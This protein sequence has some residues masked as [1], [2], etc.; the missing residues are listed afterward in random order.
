MLRTALRSRELIILAAVALVLALLTLSTTTVAAG[1]LPGETV[2][3]EL[4][5][6]PVLLSLPGEG[7]EPKGLVLFFHGQGGDVN[8]RVGDP[9]L[10]TLRRDGWAVASSNYHEE[11]WGNAAST[12]DVRRLTR[13]AKEQTGLAP[14][15]Y[16]AGSMGAAVSLNAMLHGVN[17]P[18]CWYGVRPA[19]DLT[20]MDRVPGARRFIREAFDGPVPTDRDP[21]DNV[22][23]L[24]AQTR[25][26]VIASRDDPEVT[27]EQNAEV[28]V[29]SLLERGV[30]VTEQQVYGGHDDPSH[31]NAH[32][33]LAF[34]NTCLDS[35]RA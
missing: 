21:I 1:E 15:V 27:Y 34:A 7:I 35:G 17:A 26:R 23:S 4:A 29:D 12:E 28:F 10:D 18:D 30:D 11:S 16:V 20:E 14:S 6:Q 32:D 24:P 8:V 22:A 2:R 31:F 3:A 33:V 9:F 13:W 25:Y 5:G 19:L